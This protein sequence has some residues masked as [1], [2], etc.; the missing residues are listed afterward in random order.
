ME[1]DG[2]KRFKGIGI[3]ITICFWSILSYGQQCPEL[4]N[5]VDGAIEVPV[6]TTINWPKIDGV[7][8]YLISLGT[9]RGGTDI[10]NRRSAGLTNSFVPPVGL[11]DDT[12][13]YVTI[14]MFLPGQQLVI[15][16]G[17]SFSTIDVTK[18]P[19]CT[20]LIEPADS[21]TNI[22]VNQ[23][24]T[25][26]YAPTATGYR[27]SIGTAAGVFDIANDIDVGN[28]L[29]Y[30]PPGEFELDKE[31]FVKIVPYNE[32]GSAPSCLTESFVTG[33][34]TF[35]CEAAI[36][37]ITGATY[38]LKPEINFPDYI[39]LCENEETK[40]IRSEDKARGFRWFSINQ[41]G[42]ETLISNN[43]E[44]ELEGLGR[45]RYEA[46]NSTQV[47]GSTFEC[48]S[49]KEFELIGSV[50]PTIDKI[51]VT[52]EVDGLTITVN[53]SGSGNYEFALDEEDG[54]Y[55]DSN[56]F[57]GIP[58]GEHVVFVRDKDGCGVISRIVERNLSAKD[59][60]QF[61]S[62]NGDG[63][64]DYWQ[65]DPPS[66]LDVS[67]EVIRI[68]DRYGNFLVQIN[69]EKKGWNGILNGRE[70][71]ASDYWFKATSVSQ[72]EVFGHFALVR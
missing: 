32:N 17:E 11:P 19:P 46:F 30:N 1:I 56:Y 26:A 61:F 45:Y 31:I 70:L 27:V 48:S 35:D 49:S 25:W 16:P 21:A 34:P 29:S 4:T 2:F 71:P 59:F 13:I 64:N 23:N 55:Q 37:P 5:P 67:L 38:S 15:C 47:F 58:L 9:T 22:S 42:S 66:D 36:D 10:L 41:D 39:S 3:L 7:V 43:N 53:I 18:P 44:V 65:F 14:E 60:P 50:L 68:Y 54:N 8:G 40:F 62:P 12:I 33:V 52:R 69:P 24:L 28:V 6:N 51:N 20:R 72:K 63:I 57:Q